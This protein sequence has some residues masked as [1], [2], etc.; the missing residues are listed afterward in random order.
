M[1]TN[2]LAKYILGVLFGCVIK[3]VDAQL[4]FKYKAELENVH[5][6]GFYEIVLL[7]SVTAKLQPGFQDIRIINAEGKQVPFMMQSDV[8]LPVR[9]TSLK[10]L[11]ILSNKKE[12]DKLTHV[13]IENKLNIPIN[14]LVLFIKNTEATR[15][16]TIAG[17][18]NNREWYVIKEE[19][20][21]KNLF[22]ERADSVAQEVRFPN[23]NYRYFKLIIHGTDVLPVNI[24]RVCTQ[25]DGPN[26]NTN[27]IPLP[28]P[29]VEQKDS[30]D[31]FSYV[32]IRFDDLYPINKLNLKVSGS[33]F[34][35]RTLHIYNKNSSSNNIGPLLLSSNTS[36]VY[37]L[38]IKTNQVLLKISNEDNPPLKITE[39]SAFQVKWHL[40]TWLE[41][42]S[43]YKIVFGDSM[44]RAPDY[45][46]GFFKDSITSKPLSLTYNA[47][48]KNTIAEQKE[49]TNI[50][51]SKTVM[52][53]VIGVVLSILLFFTFRL[54][55]DIS[56]KE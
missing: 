30:S 19:V 9:Y 15:N 42:D 44:A 5:A 24:I 10:E 16:V 32:T 53:G 51:S 47:P 17:S 41:K 54:T 6:A 27:Y 26:L 50:F 7:P 48:K 23:S 11:P 25:G 21:L 29:S 36:P 1:Q 22:T 56:S 38:N 4:A 39:V 33:K 55:K 12:T 2:V 13:I 28:N 45:D 18:D 31:H 52:W 35:R 34:F 49:T 46:L 14:S 43:G 37:S 8:H 3:T 40:L 20:S